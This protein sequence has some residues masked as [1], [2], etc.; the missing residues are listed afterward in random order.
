MDVM[1]NTTVFVEDGRGFR[2]VCLRLWK[3]NKVAVACAAVIFVF[4]LAALLAPVLTPYSYEEI[5]STGRLAK[6]SPS[7]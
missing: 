2:A 6:P 5:T 3:E 1:E 7:S 4:A